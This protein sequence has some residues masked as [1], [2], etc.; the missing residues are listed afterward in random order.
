MV[1]VKQ[2]LLI[3]AESYYKDVYLEAI[4]NEFC[5]TSLVPKKARMERQN[6]P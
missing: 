6:S 3:S 5:G 4:P 1:T 2:I